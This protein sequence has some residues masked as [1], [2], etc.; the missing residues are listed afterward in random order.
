MKLFSAPKGEK[1]T[2]R[3]KKEG[4]EEAINGEEYAKHTHKTETLFPENEL[5][6]PE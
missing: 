4:G 1:Q 3:N 6:N 2:Q 5:R